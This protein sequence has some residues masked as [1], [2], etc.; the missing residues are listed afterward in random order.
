[1]SWH[2]EAPFQR[3]GE[4]ASNSVF[5][6]CDFGMSLLVARER[7]TRF[8]RR[9][10]PSDDDNQMKMSL[11][12][13]AHRVDP[14]IDQEGPL[15]KGNRTTL[16]NREDRRPRGVAKNRRASRIIRPERATGHRIIA[17]RRNNSSHLHR[18]WRAT[19]RFCVIL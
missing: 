6:L 1:M 13:L 18:P 8:A 17:P 2:G 3:F 15:S 19:V 4:A 5:G 9:T 10:F 7:Q 12:E 11:P 14:E 16:R